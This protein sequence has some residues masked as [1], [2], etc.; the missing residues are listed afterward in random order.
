VEDQ[1]GNQAITEVALGLVMA[2]FALMVIALM[3]MSI[4]SDQSSSLGNVSIQVSEKA[5]R[6]ARKDGLSKQQQKDEWIIYYQGNY[7]DEEL[8]LIDHSA[9]SKSKRYYLA[10]SPH[11]S[12]QEVLKVRS[13]IYVPNLSITELNEDWL[14]RLKHLK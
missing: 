5:E 3:S 1:S 8:S 2:F 9:L 6:T 14:A 11:L 12:F 7:Y 10:L 13:G 4:K